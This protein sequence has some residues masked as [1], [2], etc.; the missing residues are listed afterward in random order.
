MEFRHTVLVDDESYASAGT[1][2]YDL[3][4][5]ALSHIILTI[6]A[7]NNGAKAT[8]SDLL[9]ALTNI[10][11]LRFGSAIVS[12]SAQDLYAL[13]C[14]LLGRE[15]WQENVVDTDNAVRHLSLILPFG[16]KLY[17]P[18]ECLPPTI[19]GELTLRIT[20]AASG[21][22]WDGLIMQIETV[23]LLD[24]NPQ[25]HLKY[26]TI[27][28]TPTSTGDWDIELPIGLKYL[29]ILIYSTTV[30]TGTS[31]TTTVDKVTLLAD[32]VERYYRDVNWESLHGMLI[33]RLSPANA[34]GEKFHYVPAAT[35]SAGEGD[36]ETEQQDD[37]DIANYAY[38]DFDPLGDDNYL[39]DSAGLS[40]LVLR[41][42]AGDTNAI[43]VIP[44]QLM[45]P[46]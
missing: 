39:F 12:I 9:G 11:V 34:W 30:P 41:V 8:L 42:T 13:N 38:L 26:T 33:N 32:N 31:W 25:Q 1:H 45:R 3:P 10:E 27:T 4:I 19:R 18:N 7:L 46:S 20:N 44:I 16:R 5:N 6:K 28:S 36:T 23:E 14:V 37:T 17:D 29:G 2:T 35:I 21:T 24:A 22:A 15:P 43:R 40:S